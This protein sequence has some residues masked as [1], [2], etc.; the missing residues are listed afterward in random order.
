MHLKAA[1]I[2]LKLSKCIFGTQK[3]EYLG[4]ELSRGGVKPQ[5]KLIKAIK[6]FVIPHSKKE[7]KRIL[8]MAGFYRNF[9]KDFADVSKP[10]CNLT[11]E[12]LQ[13]NWE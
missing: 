3:V 9:I 7:V 5:Y 11:Q 8:G 6:K 4:Y 12:N 10:W 1:N 13:F 2:S